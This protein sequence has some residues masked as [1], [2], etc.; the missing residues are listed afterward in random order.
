MTFAAILPLIIADLQRDWSDVVSCVD[1]SK[2]GIGIVAGG[3]VSEDVRRCGRW[4]ERWRYKRL[5]PEEWQPRKRSLAQVA[6]GQEYVRSA[7]CDQPQLDHRILP[8]YL[9]KGFP[10]I[11]D[12][13]IHDIHWSTVTAKPMLF[14][15]PI[16]ILEARAVLL[17]LEQIA[18]Y[19]ESH[20][21][22]HLIL[23]DNMSIVL[24][25]SSRSFFI[26]L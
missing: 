11:P 17:R 7:V 26:G 5:P 14:N 6:S 23:S 22:K 13:F 10:E 24:S 1:A 4:H 12:K 8:L 21:K 3:A 19:P 20:H 15:E 16:H 2:S 18:S 9:D 25:V